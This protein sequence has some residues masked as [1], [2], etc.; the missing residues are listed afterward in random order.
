MV[1]KGVF[2]KNLLFSKFKWLYPSTKMPI[3]PMFFKQIE[4]FQCLNTSTTQGLSTGII[5]MHV[6]RVTC[7]QTCLEVSQL[8][9]SKKSKH[10]TCLIWGHIVRWW[11]MPCGHFAI[12]LGS[13]PPFKTI[14][15]FCTHVLNC[16][17]RIIS[18]VCRALINQ[19][20]TT[21]DFR[22]IWEPQLWL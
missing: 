3:T 1:E 15:W 22:N 18:K 16:K 2:P 19:G 9:W 10:L 4:K 5:R 6:T 21:K 13:G 20:K 17:T 7:P 12:W 11:V 14:L 8:F